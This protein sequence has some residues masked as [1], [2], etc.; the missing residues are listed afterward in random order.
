MGFDNKRV[1]LGREEERNE[2]LIQNDGPRLGELDGLIVRTRLNDIMDLD[3]N[4]NITILNFWL[5]HRDSTEFSESIL[6]ILAQQPSQ[7]Q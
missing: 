6:A 5:F 7:P 3:R 1:I 4:N 2:F